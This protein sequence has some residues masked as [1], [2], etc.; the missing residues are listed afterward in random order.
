M[1]FTRTSSGLGNQYFFY[2]VDA[3]VFTEGGDVSW[4]FEDIRNNEFNENSVDILFWK[5]L[6]QSFKSDLNLKFKAV[7]SKTTV[8]AIALEI[9]SKNLNT[10]IAAMDSEFDHVHNHCIVHP[11][12]LYTHGYSW[13]NDVWDSSIIV[14]LLENVS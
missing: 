4:T 12:V 6:F 11:N 14:S 10:V 13:E 1:S 5:K 9:K 8:S 7:G 3:V 2:D